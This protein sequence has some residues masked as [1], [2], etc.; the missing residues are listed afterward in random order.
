MG[1][2]HIKQDQGG[3]N[4]IRPDIPYGQKIWEGEG[5]LFFP[6]GAKDPKGRLYFPPFIDR[7]HFLV[8]DGLKEIWEGH[9]PGMGYRPCALGGIT[10][11]VVEVYWFIRPAIVDCVSG[12]TKYYKDDSIEQLC[13]APEAIGGRE[14]FLVEAKRTVRL[15]LS[16]D[17][18]EQMYAKGMQG[19]VVER[20]LLGE[21]DRDG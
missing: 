19:F 3:D 15:I 12:A 16:L 13:L 18:L 17:V 1:Y 20:V 6:V 11:G 14:I 9:Q 7:P 21:E 4:Q 2:Y 5:P 8:S 10:Q